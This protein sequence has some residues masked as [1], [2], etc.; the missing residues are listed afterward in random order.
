ML[1][2]SQIKHYRSLSLKKNRDKARIFVAEG[3]KLV[4]DLLPYFEPEVIIIEDSYRTEFKDFEVEITE[5]EDIQKISLQ[6]HPQGV[7][8]TFKRKV[9]NLHHCHPEK[10]L[11]LAMDD[12]QDPGNMGT[13]IRICDWFGIKHIVCSNQTVDIYNPKVVQSTMGALGRVNVHYTDLKTYIEQSKAPAFGTFLK[14]E[15]IYSNQLPENG[16]IVMGNEGNGISKPIEESITHKLFIPP[17]PGNSNTSESLN[18]ATATAI[19]C[20]EFRRK[21]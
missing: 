13:I 1:S 15:N 6:K 9:S 14:G 8:A 17:F 18:V 19:V 3:P 20:S 12:V 11:V 4:L 21:A 2:K 7:Y 16:I 10:E 5:R